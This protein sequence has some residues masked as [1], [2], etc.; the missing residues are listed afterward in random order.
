M[1][2]DFTSCKTPSFEESSRRIR[3]TATSSPPITS[4]QNF[5]QKK[6]RVGILSW[7]FQSQ[8]VYKRNVCK[9]MRKKRKKIGTYSGF[10]KFKRMNL[11]H[12]ETHFE[13][14]FRNFKVISKTKN[15]NIKIRDYF[16][17]FFLFSN[18]MNWK[19]IKNYY[20]HPLLNYYYYT[21]NKRPTVQSSLELDQ[22][23]HS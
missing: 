23:K 1:V 21:P 11:L 8:K 19:F 15:K 6:V 20:D 3:S 10:V 17:L 13:F 2:N 12:L 7:I 14:Y 4:K 5:F 16:F 18:K 9:L 22:Q